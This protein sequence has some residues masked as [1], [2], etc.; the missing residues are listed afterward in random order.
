MNTDLR[1]LLGPLIAVVILGVIGFQTRDA[2]NSSGAWASRRPR[3]TPATFDPYA[4]LESQLSSRDS[5]VQVRALR[6]PFAYGRAPEPT[7]KHV[8]RI[9]T[10]PAPPKPLLTAILSGADPRALVRY[11]DHD[12]TI[13]AGDQF[14]DFKVISITAEAVV[15]ERGG[16]RLSLNRPTKG[17]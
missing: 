2:L 13:K 6:D 16:Q 9:V 7:T 3:H 8:T 12:Y 11:M 17:E 14:A 10:P 1:G 5:A 15:L 4:R